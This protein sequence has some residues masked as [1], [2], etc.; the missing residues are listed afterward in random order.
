[1]KRGPLEPSSPGKQALTSRGA[2]GEESSSEHPAQGGVQAAAR[3]RNQ[4]RAERAKAPAREP[5]AAPAATFGEG[6]GGGG[7]G[8]GGMDS[9]TSPRLALEPDSPAKRAPGVPVAVGSASEADR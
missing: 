3:P 8:E 4:P 5:S 9:T 6:G 2:S 1:M 7:G